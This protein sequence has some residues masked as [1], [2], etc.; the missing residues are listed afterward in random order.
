MMETEL[1]GR[2]AELMLRAALGN[3]MS[4]AMYEGFCAGNAQ[5]LVHGVV[6]C[7]APT[8]DILRRA[9]SEKK[10]LLV[11]REHPYFLHGGIH[12]SYGT[13]VRQ[14]TGSRFVG[15][16]APHDTKG[17]PDR[18]SVGGVAGSSPVVP[19]ILFQSV[20]DIYHECTANTFGGLAALRITLVSSTT[21][22]LRRPQ[23]LGN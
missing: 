9:A 19:A 11:S 3:R 10:T 15:Q 6:I 22:R 13:D 17:I 21:C 7:Y 4:T 18:R 1:T 8:L 2:T 12:Y 5:W 16:R 14:K 20:S 23:S